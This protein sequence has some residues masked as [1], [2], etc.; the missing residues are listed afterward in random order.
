MAGGRED[1][2][3]SWTFPQPDHGLSCIVTILKF[4]WVLSPLLNDQENLA[5]GSGQPRRAQ[6]VQTDFAL[7]QHETVCH[8]TH[9]YGFLP[10]SMTNYQRASDLCPHGF[11]VGRWSRP[12]VRE[13]PGAGRWQGGAW[14]KPL[15]C[16]RLLCHCRHPELH[17]FW[18]AST[19]HPGDRPC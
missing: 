18:L 16:A 11:A 15:P 3:R 7:K 19:P 13:D 4:Y 12:S 1:S 10:F 14:G 17:T 6:P 9:I 8:S 2:R 5:P